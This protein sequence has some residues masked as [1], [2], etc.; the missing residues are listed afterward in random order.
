[1][2]QQIALKDMQQIASFLPNSAASAKSDASPLR[3]SLSQ[4][5]SESTLGMLGAQ[6][7]AKQSFNS[8][9]LRQTQQIQ[10]FEQPRQRPI[11]LSDNHNNNTPQSANSASSREP[12]S[13][14]QSANPP[15]SSQDNSYRRDTANEAMKSEDKSVNVNKDHERS[16]NGYNSTKQRAQD[17]ASEKGLLRADQ[18]EHSAKQQNKSNDTTSNE[19]RQAQHDSPSADKV[20]SST[21]QRNHDASAV[22]TANTHH[23]EIDK[24]VGDEM[25]SAESGSDDFDYIEYVTALATFNTSNDDVGKNA[26]VNIDAEEPDLL[27]N[28]LAMSESTLKQEIALTQS[29]LGT[30]QEGLN[31]SLSTVL[32]E[33]SRHEEQALK[34]MLELDISDKQK[35]PENLD[36]LTHIDVSVDSLQALMKAKENVSNDDMSSLSHGEIDANMSGTINDIANDIANEIVSQLNST[37]ASTAQS[38]QV[39]SRESDKAL[40]SN[41]LLGKDNTKQFD[42]KNLQDNAAQIPNDKTDGLSPQD[43]LKSQTNAEINKGTLSNGLDKN[44]LLDAHTNATGMAK[45]NNDAK[46]SQAAP[47]G[48]MTL[49]ELNEMQSKAALEN[50]S[51][52]LQAVAT[53]LSG[54]NKGNEFIIALQSGVK[55]FKA[56]L[57][58]GREPGID[59]KALITDALGQV[60]GE[61]SG[62]QQPKIDAA[63]TQFSK[64]LQAAGALNLAMGQA[65]AQSAGVNDGQFAKEN[66]AIQLEGTKLAN[67][68]TSSANNPLNAQASIDKAIN[69]FKAEGQNQLAEK[70]RWMVNARHA[71]AEIR[72]DPADL[73]GINI[74]INLS[75]DTAQ[76]NFN[77]QSIVAKEALDQAAPRL[78]EMLQDQGIELGQSS[79]QQDAKGSGQDQ[80][81]DGQ[82]EQQ[83]AG[84]AMQQMTA[85]LSSDAAIEEQ[86]L[87]MREQRITNGA[88]GGIDYYA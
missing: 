33:T 40:I 81:S 14:N 88:I 11:A 87:H 35:M 46:L 50:L 72:L 31:A 51:Q 60:T 12:M 39:N 75:G 82:N 62:A 80:A 3:F 48:L 74:K 69:I 36:T 52:R 49:A 9:L 25:L 24:A 21:Q 83:G 76:V 22:Q 65:Q 7:N 37:A 54:E 57:A 43:L 29:E 8:E 73:G 2:V 17:S 4:S 47:S 38:E 61:I 34:A 64:A 42:I 5:T 84:N 20:A 78:R 55:E 66:S 70:V 68:V 77:V 15:H 10:V 45:D 44:A 13:R 71:T 59:L 16:S 27:S 23:D 86:S 18:V 19:T 85:S 63:M 79:V 6:Y 30:D 26:E 53:Q 28:L 56:Q 58:Q 32:G 67:G 1:M 41:L